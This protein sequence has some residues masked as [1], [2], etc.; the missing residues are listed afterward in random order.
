VTSASETFTAAASARLR[1]ERLGLARARALMAGDLTVVDAAPGW[2]HAD[3]L[4][5]I[6]LEA[7]HA[8]DDEATSFLVILTESGQVIGEAGWKGGP[9]DQ[10]IAEIGYGLASP[11]RGQGLG[12]EMVGLLAGCVLAQPG[13]SQVVA[14]VLPGNAASRRALE[15]NG[16]EIDRSAAEAGGEMR[17]V[18]RPAAICA[19]RAGGAARTDQA[20]MADHADHA[21]HA[22]QALVAA[23]RA[24]LAAGA[25]P[26]KAAPMAAY[27]KSAMPYRGVASP[28]QKV[29]FRQVLA[30]HPLRDRDAW[31]DTVRALWDGASYREERYAAIAVAADA[32]Y[33]ALRDPAA[34]D[35]LEH[36]LVTG[37]WWDL[38]DPVATRCVGPA[39][40]AHP[41][42]L[43]PVMAAWAAGPDLWLRRTAIIHQVGAK[44]QTDPDLL[45][46]C[47][48]PS[49][50]R[51]EFF[52]RKA[53]GW[54][55]RDLAWR[56]PA[57]VRAYVR[58]H[59]DVLSGLSAREALKNC[60]PG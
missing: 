14:C 37:A 16:F 33:T 45:A 52:L 19:D 34:M 29:L 28:E 31:Q 13:V 56:D 59:Q 27:M 21:D 10:G 6:A 43:V 42:E 7:E 18:R 41:A 1:L 50:A 55:L 30:D 38:V 3:S 4:D 36:L 22:D 17:Y 2:P 57:W 49:L 26:A 5:G 20:Q 48:A 32:A 23:I 39:V 11:S 12:T 53:I 40:R 25:D 44:A 9:D 47:I 58:A 51:T 60:G 46:R 54:A 8:D 24:G 15:R 35:L